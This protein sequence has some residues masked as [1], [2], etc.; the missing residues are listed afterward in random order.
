MEA[1]NAAWEDELLLKSQ[2]PFFSRKDKANLE[3]VGDD[4]TMGHQG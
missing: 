1:A 2:F 4:R 3:G